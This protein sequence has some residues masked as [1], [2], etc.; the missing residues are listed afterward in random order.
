[1]SKPLYRREIV[2]A[3]RFAKE[4]TVRRQNREGEQR[5]NLAERIHAATLRMINVIGAPETTYAFDGE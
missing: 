3:R 4:A 2:K 5:L 1:M